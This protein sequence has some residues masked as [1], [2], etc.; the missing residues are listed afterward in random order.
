[1]ARKT[2]QGIDV[3]RLDQEI[4]DLG[5][6]VK[7][8]KSAICPNMSS[9]ESLDHDVNCTVCNN[10]MID[11][12]PKETVAI[13]QQQDFQEMFKVQGT[14]HVDEVI[15]T[16]LSGE[17]LQLYTR[18][19]LLD[20]PEDFIELVQRQDFATT[21]TDVLKYKA[22]KILGCFVVRAGVLKRFHA[23]AD[24]VLDQNGSIKWISSNR[25]DDREIYSIYYKYLP[26]YRAVKAVHRD[27]FSQ[28]N[29]RPDKIAAPKKK[30]GEATYVKLPETWVLKRDYLI[31]RR[32]GG[33]PTGA[34]L[35]KNEFY[36]P[37][38]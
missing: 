21:D 28:F 32:E 37:N 35:T 8:Y 15:V 9:L 12:D 6:R 5:V 14:F 24:F 20:F 29:N 22:C 16:F 33:T 4:R 11:F 10:N 34:K 23:G 13:F 25:P 17:T 27:R 38:E 30:V 18:V 19:E 2:S 3:D 1:M 36:D 31:E 26:V 7:L